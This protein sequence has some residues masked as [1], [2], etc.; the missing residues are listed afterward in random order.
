MDKEICPRCGQLLQLRWDR[1]SRCW[2]DWCISCSYELITTPIENIILPKECRQ[3]EK[4]YFAPDARNRQRI[5]FWIR[6]CDICGE[7]FNS[8]SSKR[9]VCY[10]LACVRKRNNRIQADF[11][12]MN[13]EKL[14]FQTSQ[15]RIRLKLER[16]SLRP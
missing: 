4:I 14:K 3:V 13:K 10:E 1:G 12:R 5:Q 6:T 8:R 15:R 16:L 7:R 9:D 2:I 11:K